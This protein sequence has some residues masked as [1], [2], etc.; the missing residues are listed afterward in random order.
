MKITKLNRIMISVF[1]IFVITNII[2]TMSSRM[3]S[4]TLRGVTGQGDSYRLVLDAIWQSL[5]DL[6]DLSREYV[7][8]ADPELLQS[9]FNEA[10]ISRLRAMFNDLSNELYVSQYEFGLMELFFSYFETSLEFDLQAFSYIDDGEWY[11]AVDLL[12]GNEYSA[13]FGTAIETL[14]AVYEEVEIRLDSYAGELFQT[15]ALL[16][17]ISMIATIIS[18]ILMIVGMGYNNKKIA[19]IDNL[20]K[21]IGEVADGHLHINLKCDIE[22]KNEMDQITVGVCK[23][24]SRFQIMTDDLNKATYNFAVLG[25]MDYRIDVTPY[26][27]D[28]RNLAENTNKLMQ[29]FVDEI[30]ATQNIVTSLADG[31][32]DISIPELPGKKAIL[33]QTLRKIVST[34]D[35]LNAN[36]NMV[37]IGA[38][39]G[40]FN[41]HIDET[42][43]EGKWGRA[44]GRLNN[45]AQV[46]RDM[47]EA[48]KQ[49]SIYMSE[50]N[51]SL[52]DL[53]GST[54]RPGIYGEVQYAFNLG[55]ITTNNLIKDIAAVLSSIAQGDLTVRTKET[56]KGSY[57]A[58][59]DSINTIL[60]T[61]NN[62]LSEV[63]EMSH[64]VAFSAE[65]ISK[66][67]TQLANDTTNQSASIQEL[68]TSISYVHSKAMQTSSDAETTS[69][70]TEIM[71]NSVRTGNIAVKSMTDVMNLIKGSS[72]DI[73]KIIT[74]ITNI[75]FQTN[76]LALNASVEAARAGEHGKGFAVV[77]DEVRS[78]A[79]RS[80]QSATET[81]EIVSK[82]LHHV[83][84]ALKVTNDVVKS[85][86]TIQAN[87]IE[88]S[89]FV[90]RISKAS[91]E[92]LSLL[93]NMNESAESIAHLITKSAAASEISA[94]AA[95]EL[96]SQADKLDKQ[97]EFFRLR[98]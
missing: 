47:F 81:Q 3:A 20:A 57:S 22:S 59:E 90:A 74:V 80:Q 40:D 76:L 36:I 67:A 88:I 27:N 2:L 85:F 48:I 39:E 50:G 21:T 56:Y 32:F 8:T 31:D 58:I 86:E 82:D 18:G 93:T 51:F 94:T 34:L 75:S 77:A 10:D 41:K 95:E 6:R 68:S 54:S 12:F 62:I 78:L 24:V 13:N 29:S 25:D 17:R 71:R 44:V 46:V 83:Q 96:N 61:L 52:M 72:E 16:S 4:E 69:K 19:P 45:L 55:G 42:K 35:D 70:N 5:Y 26:T 97:V 84:E 14:T 65:A 60:D 91:L 43:F 89:E 23:L 38:T 15:Y 79:G 7:I 11:L 66:E 9:H 98:S 49:E 73:E 37:V 64:K 53:D 33:T 30:L 28:F 63:A 92:Q 87:I 1:L